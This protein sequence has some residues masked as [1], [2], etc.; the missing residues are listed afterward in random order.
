M[1]DRERDY[2]AV[3][4]TLSPAGTLEARMRRVVDALWSALEGAGV[5]WLGFYL[6]HPGE[7]DDR[8]LVLGPHRDAPACSP[9][10]S[11]GVCG[12]ALCGGR[13][14]IVHDVNELG[15]D[16]VA[17]DPRDRSELVI[18]L[19]DELGVTW[20]VLDLDAREVGAFSA[21]DAAGLERVLRAG[22]L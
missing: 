21:V 8:R 2:D 17:C 16:Y 19:V 22:G 11:H 5:S 4:A 12:Q 7:P 15:P 20:A 6:D 14:R 3:A 1:A 13:I 10:G 9:I 18:P